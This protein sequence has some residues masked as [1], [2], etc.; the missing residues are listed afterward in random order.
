[1]N[2]FFKNSQPFIPPFQ[3]CPNF[4]QLPNAFPFPPPNYVANDFIRNTPAFQQNFPFLSPPNLFN[5]NFQTD[6]VP[7]NFSQ[8]NSINENN[9][10]DIPIYPKLNRT[11]GIE[12]VSNTENL[13]WIHKWVEINK[14][15]LFQPQKQSFL[16]V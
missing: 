10:Q 8:D 12:A 3:R 1:M 14:V 11:N 4:A 9:Y 16:T 6:F 7:K 13:N 2:P 5:T 15:Q